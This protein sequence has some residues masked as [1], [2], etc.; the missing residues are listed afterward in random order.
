MVCVA[1]L[2]QRRSAV[3]TRRRL[4]RFD[5]LRVG[6][7]KA[8]AFTSTLHSQRLAALLGIALGVS[9]SICFVTGLLS[10]LIQTPPAWFTWPARP[11]G[12]Y[13]VTQGLHVATGFASIPLLLAKLWIAYPRLWAWPPVAGLLHL[14]ERVSLIPLVGGSLFLLF[15]GVLNI[16]FWYPWGFF[17][18]TGHY[19]AAW[20][21]IGALV[22]HIGA[23]ATIAR[24]AL[25]RSRS[26]ANGRM[27]GGLTRRGF[28]GA[29][30]G[31]MGLITLTTAGQTFSPLRGLAFLAPYVP[32][33]GPQGFPV[34]GTPNADTVKQ[35][36]QI[37]TYRLMVSGAVSRPLE[38]SLE[39]LQA[40]LQHEA[41]LPISCVNGWSQT[42]RWKGVRLA[43]LVVMAGAPSDSSVTVQS[44]Q[45][46]T[47]DV[48]LVN[49]V[50]LQDPDTM[51][52]LA[53]NGEP[54]H[55]DHGFPVRLIGPNRPGVTNTKWVQRVSVD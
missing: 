33:V 10:D 53:V 27:P 47:Y 41:D 19:W 2:V 7:L 22:V 5:R 54:L 42:L 24:H 31:A 48:S 49:P 52:A 46:G 15:T 51:L 39:D 50:Q 25:G 14:V 28:L 13:R 55:V 45:P 29:V 35:A 34:V 4:A 30:T 1:R 26:L 9:F 36:Q 38:L 20:I 37:G 40:L 12:L 18:P 16:G 21:T 8:E 23:K 3:S 11:V 43:D 6:P 32:G 17:F 44:L